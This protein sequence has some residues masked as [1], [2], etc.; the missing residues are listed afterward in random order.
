MST[1]S[2]SCLPRDR[3]REKVDPESKVRRILAKG[4]GE[5]R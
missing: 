2:S 4:E 3:K 1:K 5:E